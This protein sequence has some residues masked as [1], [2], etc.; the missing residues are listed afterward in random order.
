MRL[1]DRFLFRVLPWAGYVIIK[2]AG[3]TQRTRVVNLRAVR[4]VFAK[5]GRAIFAFWHNRLMM[6]PYIYRRLFGMKDIVTLISLSREGEFFVRA[7]T[8]FRPFVV[9]GSSTRGGSRAFKALVRRIEEG[10]D[11]IIT[12]DGPVGP[13]Y[14]IQPGIIALARMTG[15]PIIPAGYWSSR[16][17][18]FSTWDG[19]ILSL[20]FGRTTYVFGEPLYCS[21]HASDSQIENLAQDLREALLAV[22]RR[23]GETLP[24]WVLSQTT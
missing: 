9:R 14:Q 6:I 23:A 24:N 5:H 20:P 16:S 22:S 12:P 7:L 3:V 1:I 13:R 4:R 19:F 2:G 11:C 10:M 17:K 21:P 8:F 18:T 15:L